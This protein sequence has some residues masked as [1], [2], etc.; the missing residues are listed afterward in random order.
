MKRNSTTIYLES[1]NATTPLPWGNNAPDFSGIDEPTLSALQQAW[2][3]FL[4]TGEELEIIPDPPPPP[5]EPDWLGFR[6]AMIPPS[7]GASSFEAW[8]EQAKPL[9]QAAVTAAAMSAD[10]S[11]L[12]QIY[13]LLKGLYPPS[14]EQVAEWQGVANTYHIGLVF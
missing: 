9:Y 10:L 5:P 3:D 12:Q 6:L 8:L 1:L 4:A 13:S 11:E 14:P 2:A 7:G